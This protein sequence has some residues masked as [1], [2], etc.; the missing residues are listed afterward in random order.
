M[1]TALK[2]YSNNQLETISFMGFMGHT[3]YCQWEF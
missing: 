1:F 3:G 2:L